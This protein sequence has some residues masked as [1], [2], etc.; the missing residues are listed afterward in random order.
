MRLINAIINRPLKPTDTRVRVLLIEWR[1]YR[2][3]LPVR[4]APAFIDVVHRALSKCER[5][6]NRNRFAIKYLFIVRDERI[7]IGVVNRLRITRQR[8]SVG[9]RR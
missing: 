1:R 5:V 3:T 6:D 8:F 2:Q 4:R 9:R 7:L